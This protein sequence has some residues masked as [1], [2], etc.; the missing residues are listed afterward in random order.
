MDRFSEFVRARE[1]CRDF[2][3]DVPPMAKLRACVETARLAPS[4]CNSQPWH[5]VAVNDPAL[6]AGVGAATRSRRMNAFTEHCP[7]YIVVCEEPATLSPRVAAFV[8]SQSYA[9]ID[10]GIV[11]AHLCYA[12]Q[13][14]GLSTCIL[15]WFDGERLRELLS[16]PENRRVRLVVA[17]GTAAPGTQLRPKKRR[18]TDEVLTCLGE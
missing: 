7:A 4:A 1:S 3:P 8:E 15:G 18:E 5:F 12:A 10:I 13:E 2:A 17:V 11:T 16:L 14:Q 6:A 9:S